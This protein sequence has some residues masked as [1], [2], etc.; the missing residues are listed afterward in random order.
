MRNLRTEIQIKNGNTIKNKM[1]LQTL[2]GHFKDQEKQ[3]LCLVK[4]K[5][6][7]FQEKKLKM[8]ISQ[9]NDGYISFLAQTIYNS[10]I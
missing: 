9:V 7:G 4:G 6:K 8:E 3:I 10:R 1:T 5:E 2:K